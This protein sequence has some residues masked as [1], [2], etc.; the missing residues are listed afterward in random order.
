MK[1]NAPKNQT[2]L[3]LFVIVLLSFF[4]CKRNYSVYSS[5]PISLSENLENIKDSFEIRN[6][7]TKFKIHIDDNNTLFWFPD[8]NKSI[9]D[10]KADKIY[11]YV[12]LKG[13]ML[14]NAVDSITV[15]TTNYQKYLLV[16][17]D[18]KG[19]NF[20][21]L[22][23]LVDS[24]QKN[25]KNRDFFKDFTG[26]MVISD[27]KTSK[28]KIFRFNNK[29]IENPKL[30]TTQARSFVT[31]CIPSTI[32]S[33]GMLCSSDGYNYHSMITIV[34]GNNCIE[35]TVKPYYCPHESWDLVESRSECKYQ[36]I[37]IPEDP[38]V[39]P[40]QP[41]DP[42]PTPPQPPIIGTPPTSDILPISEACEQMSYDAIAQDMN[43]INDINKPKYP[44]QALPTWAKVFEGYPSVR[45]SDGTYGDLPATQVYEKI[46][47]PLGD[48]AKRNPNSYTNAC[49]ARV[50]MGL[51]N[52][53]INIPN[54]PGSTY[55]GAG[56]K[57]YF[58][59]AEKLYDFVTQTFAGN[60]TWLSGGN[61][62]VSPS[63]FKSYTSGAH[64]LYLMRPTN[65]N[66]FKATGHATLFDGSTCMGG[67]HGCCFSASGGVDKIVFVKLP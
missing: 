51:I 47:G 40:S 23:Y 32:C 50:S 31:V 62:P 61:G 1:I 56:G 19:M 7:G 5:Y 8:W 25:I 3:L 26:Q 42:T 29:I 10:I 66:Q 46:G 64:G 27:L 52:A 24:V 60:Y 30:I 67:N 57:F 14:N 13:R 4:S 12:P 9:K 43:Y 15:V 41:T 18:K 16:T 48:E 58:I 34:E 65:P 22:Y 33:W 59:S 2:Q 49:A 37:W 21:E 17:L 36:T 45:Y 11:Y 20:S 44:Q 63:A 38:S 28:M 6:L 53:G 39:P 54:I 55:E 35:P